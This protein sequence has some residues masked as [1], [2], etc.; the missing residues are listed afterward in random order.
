MAIGENKT[1]MIVILVIG[2]N[3]S[4]KSTF[5]LC[6]NPLATSCALHFYMVPSGFNFFLRI[7]LQ[8]IVLHPRG[9]STKYQVLFY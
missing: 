6:L 3:V 5:Y 8:P 4:K 7:H 9:K 1:L 2:E